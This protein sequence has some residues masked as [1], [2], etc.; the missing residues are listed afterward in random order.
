MPFISCPSHTAVSPFAVVHFLLCPREDGARWAT[1]ETWVD[2]RFSFLAWTSCLC[3]V[4]LFCITDNYLRH[5]QTSQSP[6]CRVGRAFA[7]PLCPVMKNTSL[8]SPTASTRETLCQQSY[9]SSS[10]SELRVCWGSASVQCMW[11][12]PH[13][14]PRSQWNQT[15]H[16]RNHTGGS[17]VY[18][19]N[20]NPIWFC[21]ISINI[22]LLLALHVC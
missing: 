4:V 5:I 1:C 21:H 22:T 14:S 2:L 8:S 18:K 15:S 10:P 20:F 16:Y 13:M 7:V 6:F 19:C 17:R 12:P 11:N 3:T 9:F